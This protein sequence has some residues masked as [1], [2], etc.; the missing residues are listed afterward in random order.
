MWVAAFR[1]I[2]QGLAS[3]GG[4]MAKAAGSVA[5][6]EKIFGS[7]MFKSMTA[8]N[9]FS[10]AMGAMTS[11]F[12]GAMESAKQFS[13]MS[14]RLGIKPSEVA[15]L[16]Q[17]ANDAGVSLMVLG[18]AVVQTQRFGQQVN[19]SKPFKE[20]NQMLGLTNDEIARIRDGGPEAMATLAEA[21][22][23]VTDEGQ[24]MQI[25]SKLYGA[26]GAMQM[27]SV[28]ERDPE[29]IRQ[30]L[31]SFAADDF[32]IQSNAR[33]E[34]GVSKSM[35]MFKV[36]GQQLMSLMEPVI[37][38]AI[39]FGAALTLAFG[40]AIKWAGVLFDYLKLRWAAM[41]TYVASS[42]IG[43]AVLG[44]MIGDE[45]RDEYLGDRKK[46]LDNDR[47]YG[48]YKRKARDKAFD[49]LQEQANKMFAEGGDMMFGN[50][51][52]FEHLLKKKS[53]LI[54]FPQMSESDLSDMRK[55]TEVEILKATE[56][57]M[58][59]E[60][61]IALIK[62]ESDYKQLDIA[63][64]LHEIHEQDLKLVEDKAE[65][66]AKDIKEYDEALTDLYDRKKEI[67]KKIE[68]LSDMGNERVLMEDVQ[69][70][71]SWWNE[72]L[73]WGAGALTAG[74]GITAAT[75]AAP[76]TLGGSLF[77]FGA[78]AESSMEARKA[79]RNWAYQ[80]TYDD[81]QEVG[82]AGDAARRK[83]WAENPNLRA[84]RAN[85]ITALQQDRAIH[86]SNI[87]AIEAKKAQAQREMAQ[88]ATVIVPKNFEE[89][90]EKNKGRKEVATLLAEQ[91]GDIGKTASVLEGQKVA[92]F[93]RNFARMR[94]DEK[95]ADRYKGVYLRGIEKEQGPLARAEEEKKMKAQDLKAEMIQLAVMRRQ[96]EL[97]DQDLA[98]QRAE[99]EAR[100]L[101]HK[102]KG[103]QEEILPETT[104][105]GHAFTDEQIRAQR[106]KVG[107]MQ[108]EIAN[109]VQ[110]QA[111]MADSFSTAV[112]DSMRAVGGG[113]NVAAGPISVL[114]E[115]L[116]V[117]KNMRDILGDIRTSLQQ[118]GGP[119]DLGDLS[120]YASD[121]LSTSSF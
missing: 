32:T 99:V 63:K 3:F 60:Q 48:D 98:R 24:K 117:Q 69:N 91:K 89:W 85:Q 42:T 120:A 33:I 25:L 105:V 19:I 87:N 93:E 107:G 106:N 110:Q 53:L 62:K 119:G 5:N 34:S 73:G 111:E 26:R 41:Y 21:M 22:Q 52:P 68:E 95:F 88:N 16:A 71:G 108:T 116:D 103:E 79:T 30:G 86:L 78:I 29:E 81:L 49:K 15:A 77:A 44:W 12:H 13:N 118:G 83:F 28:L 17:F 9:A 57:R 114:S 59:I 70:A 115:M 55:K 10:K 67:D 97:H 113:G 121:E 1:V 50:G 43:K 36:L 66:G 37:G 75:F 109:M 90:L 82:P 23:D 102:Q 72:T 104:T 31:K 65:Q 92:M 20:V 58:S 64:K 112:G 35:N 56:D 54:R 8:A 14:L 18:K 76:E 100:N 27:K 101:E 45:A 38:L 74:A 46:D 80:D 96:R 61:K 84:S 51:N 39:Q 2:G 40:L 4:G 94:E 7:S 11:G 47:L 6:F